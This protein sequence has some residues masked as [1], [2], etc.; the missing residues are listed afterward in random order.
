MAAAAAVVAAADTGSLQQQQLFSSGSSGYNFPNALPP[1]MPYY[2]GGASMLQHGGLSSVAQLQQQAP[3]FLH[4]SGDH[5][6]LAS[7]I[8]QQ[9]HLIGGGGV[10]ENRYGSPGGSISMPRVMFQP[11]L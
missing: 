2:A 3:Y 10:G 11:V 6:N 9:Q 5:A 1:Q 4:S 8:Q 7:L